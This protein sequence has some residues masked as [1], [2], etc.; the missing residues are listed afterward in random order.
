MPCMLS[1]FVPY[2]TPTILSLY[3]W[4]IAG[5]ALPWLL[6]S[7]ARYSSHAYSFLKIKPS[8]P[9]PGALLLLFSFSLIVCSCLCG[10]QVFT[11]SSLG[12][13]AILEIFKLNLSLSCFVS[14]CLRV[15]EPG[16]EV[17]IFFLPCWLNKTWESSEKLFE[18][19]VTLGIEEAG[20][21]TVF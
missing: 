7:Q 11:M 6:P 3:L 12:K 18:G 15:W 17:R 14:W 16:V 20:M 21:V 1:C 19:G 5:C 4:I 9:N 2:C 8:C 10:N 13:K